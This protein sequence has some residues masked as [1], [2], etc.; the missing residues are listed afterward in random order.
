MIEK[1]VM[2]LRARVAKL[3]RTLELVVHQL[4]VRL[5]V[6]PPVLGVSTRVLGLARAGDKIGAIKA[7]REETGVDLAVAKRV[8]DELG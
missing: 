7:Y 5:P 6:D 4:G 2:E 1:D 8:I 3:E